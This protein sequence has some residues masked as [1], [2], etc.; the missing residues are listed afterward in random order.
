MKRSILMHHDRCRDAEREYGSGYGRRAAGEN[1]GRARYFRQ[2]G[3]KGAGRSDGL[4]AGWGRGRTRRNNS[5][6]WAQILAFGRAGCQSPGRPHSGRAN[7]QHHVD[8]A[9]L[10]KIRLLFKKKLAEAKDEATREVLRKLIAAEEAK[11][12]ADPEVPRRR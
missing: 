7:R 1:G 5:V 11:P 9:S 6:Q 10:T 3:T 2:A 8:A 12:P 4:S